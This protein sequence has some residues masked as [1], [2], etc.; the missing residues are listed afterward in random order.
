[1][2]VKFDKLER[3]SHSRLNNYSLL[4]DKDGVLLS[5]KRNHKFYRFKEVVPLKDLILNLGRDTL[6]ISDLYQIIGMFSVPHVEV[7][8][9]GRILIKDIIM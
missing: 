2:N 9:E 5:V 8:E 1:M 3:K 7:I 4:F 6:T